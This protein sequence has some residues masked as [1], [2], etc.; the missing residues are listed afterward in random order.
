LDITDDRGDLHSVARQ[1]L[2]PYVNEVTNPFVDPQTVHMAFDG[3]GNLHYL[4]GHRHVAL[5][6]FRLT[7][8]GTERE[9]LTDYGIHYEA[10]RQEKGYGTPAAPS[11]N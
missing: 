8:D 1:H 2:P 3:Q 7:A 5:G 4:L 10:V 9:L 6:P 11:K